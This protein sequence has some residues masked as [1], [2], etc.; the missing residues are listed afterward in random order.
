VTGVDGAVL[1]GIADLALRELA[2]SRATVLHDLL[3][4]RAP[5]LEALA[6]SEVT[7]ADPKLRWGDEVVPGDLVRVGARVSLLFEDRGVEGRLDGEDLCFDFEKGAIVNTLA[8]V[9]GEGARVEWSHL[10]SR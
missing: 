2:F 9:F 1:E 6:W 4:D 7:L 3:A 10:P 5:D 8:A